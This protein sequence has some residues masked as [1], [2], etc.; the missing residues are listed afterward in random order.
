VSIEQRRAIITAYTNWLPTML[1]E[2]NWKRFWVPRESTIDLS[3]S[4]YFYDPES[5]WGRFHNPTAVSLD[6]LADRPFLALLGEPGMG[7]T[8]T[9][10]REIEEVKN[11]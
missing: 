9:L 4:G 3:D 6:H 8:R 5:E 1:P 2:F 7:K 11:G 10:R